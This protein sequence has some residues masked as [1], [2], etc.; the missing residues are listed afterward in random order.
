MKTT[1][2]RAFGTVVLLFGSTFWLVLASCD[3]GG[4]ADEGVAPAAGVVAED[5]GVAA[6]SFEM[7]GMRAM[8][9]G[10]RAAGQ[11]VFDTTSP[12]QQNKRYIVTIVQ[13]GAMSASQIEALA[14]N[15]VER[16]N[17]GEVIHVYSRALRGFAA[18]LTEEEA[19]RLRTSGRFSVVEDQWARAFDFQPNPPSWGLDR[20]DQRMLALDARYNFDDSGDGVHVYVIDTGIRQSHGDFD[21]SRAVPFLD[22]FGGDSGDTQGHG[23]HVAGTIGGKTFGVAKRAHL[24]AVRTLDDFGYAPWSDIIQAIDSVIIKHR[25][26]AIINL[27]LGGPTFEQVD[28]AVQ[29][30]VRAGITVVVAAG[31]SGAD[32]CNTSPAREPLAITVGATAETDRLASFSNHGRCVDILAPGEAIISSSHADDQQSTS[33]DGTSMAAPH[34]AGAAALFLQRNSTATPAQVVDRLLSRATQGVVQGLSGGTPNLL[35]FTGS[36]ES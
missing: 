20:V 8:T 28:T 26:P 33:M 5:S 18:V 2:S 31:N 1:C 3:A 34:V 12:T 25:K 30:A 16:Q 22:L 4:G 9:A 15:I 21:G 29:K 7:A 6:Q 19:E 35:L 14:V 27:S 10:V 23:T 32:A 17:K 24:H 13:P 36:P 11:P